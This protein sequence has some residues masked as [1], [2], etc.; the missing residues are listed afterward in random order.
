[1][2]GLVNSCPKFTSYILLVGPPGMYIS[3][4]EPDRYQNH[5]GTRGE[6]LDRKIPGEV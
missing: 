4:N 1:M 6:R 3:L 2:T 5:P